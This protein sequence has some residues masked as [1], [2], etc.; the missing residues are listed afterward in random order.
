MNRDLADSDSMIRRV[1]EAYEVLLFTKTYQ[2]SFFPIMFV[3][4]FF[5]LPNISTCYVWWK[6][7]RKIGVWCEMLNWDSVRKPSFS[8]VIISLE[9]F[10]FFFKKQTHTRKREWGSNTKRLFHQSHVVVI[11]F[12]IFF[13]LNLVKSVNTDKFI[14]FVIGFRISHSLDK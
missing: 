7:K 5:L 6:E 12:W 11:M 2:I 1:I 9:V 8:L 14:D 3:C 13:L 10:F 4:F